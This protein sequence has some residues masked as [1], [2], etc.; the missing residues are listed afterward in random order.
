MLPGGPLTPMVLRSPE[1]AWREPVTTARLSGARAERTRRLTA[2][3]ARLVPRVIPSGRGTY[4][5][6]HA[7][8]ASW[9][10]ARSTVRPRR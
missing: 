3:L 8:R 2:V 5:G 9:P 6:Y 4:G 7:Q 1:S 10:G